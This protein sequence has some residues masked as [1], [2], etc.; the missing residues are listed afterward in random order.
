MKQSTGLS[1]IFSEGGLAMRLSLFALLVSILILT[2]SGI[3]GEP[4]PAQLDSESK[5]LPEVS[6]A[7]DNDSVNVVNES[8][9]NE[10]EDPEPTPSTTEGPYFKSGS[11][12]R[13]SLLE[14]GVVGD[15]VNLTGRVLTRSGRPIADALLDFWQADGN[16]RYDNVGYRLRGHQLTDDQGRYQLETVIPGNY[17]GRTKHIHVKVQAPGGAMLTTQLFFPGEENNQKDSIFMP[18]LLVSLNETEKGKEAT[19]DFVLDAK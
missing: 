2:G 10:N 15:R 9:K 12:E 6:S 17:G 13:K 5:S 8:M 7:I 4:A 3:G 16:G 1:G 19:F 11:P 18:E 14:P